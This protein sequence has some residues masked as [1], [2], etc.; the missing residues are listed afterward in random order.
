M[1]LSSA[2]GYYGRAGLVDHKNA[3]LG[4]SVI[5]VFGFGVAVLRPN[6]P[7]I[8]T[9]GPCPVRG[10]A[11]AGIRLPIRPGAQGDWGDQGPEPQE[12]LRRPTFRAGLPGDCHTLVGD[13]GAPSPFGPL[14]ALPS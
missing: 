3:R 9:S 2:I 11:R 10:G 14:G 1:K 5:G 8:R 6:H 12:D 13:P 7:E 4:V